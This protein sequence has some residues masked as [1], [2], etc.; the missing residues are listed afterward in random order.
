M[1]H[2]RLGEPHDNIWI[3]FLGDRGLI[4]GRLCQVAALTGDSC[5][6]TITPNMRSIPIT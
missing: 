6:D 5:L 4:L 3:G 2:T 1:A